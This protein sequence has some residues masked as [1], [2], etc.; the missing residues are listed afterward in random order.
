M[1]QPWWKNKNPVKFWQINKT[2]NLQEKKYC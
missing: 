1:A 2:M